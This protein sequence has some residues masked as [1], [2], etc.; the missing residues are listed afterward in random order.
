MVTGLRNHTIFLIHKGLRDFS[1]PCFF[2]LRRNWVRNLAQLHR[3]ALIVFAS[4]V[5]VHT[6][7][8]T[9]IAVPQSLLVDL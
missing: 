2:Q 6:E 8:E 5:S 3:Y 9:R 4:N 7:R 1:S